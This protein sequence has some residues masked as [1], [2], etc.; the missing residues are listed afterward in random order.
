VIVA[1]SSVWIDFLNGRL[2]DP[3]RKLFA[4]LESGRLLMGDLII[5]EVLQGVRDQGEA[6]RVQERLEAVPMARMVS[7]SVALKAAQNYR[8]LRHQ[9]ITIR[10]TVDLLIGTFC[11]ANGRQLLHSDRDFKPMVEHLGLEEA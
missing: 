4:L 2:N 1:D 6:V 5:C 3:T 10:K 11:I 9:G 8:L 7:R